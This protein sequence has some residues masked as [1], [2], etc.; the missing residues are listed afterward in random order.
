MIQ[1]EASD[2]RIV[3]VIMAEITAHRLVDQNI[4]LADSVLST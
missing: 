3:V 2:H 4:A 1:V